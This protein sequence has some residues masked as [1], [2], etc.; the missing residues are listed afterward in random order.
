MNKIVLT[1]LCGAALA[2]CV[3]EW[4]FEYIENEA[5]YSLKSDS[6]IQ[7]DFDVHSGRIDE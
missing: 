2:S 4:N 1:I 5:I 7:G 6:K 3:K